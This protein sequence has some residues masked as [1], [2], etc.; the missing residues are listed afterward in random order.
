[1]C[2]SQ[3]LFLPMNLYPGGEEGGGWGVCVCGWGGGGG[4]LRV[5]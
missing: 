4:I 2:V 1:M 3:K 5:N